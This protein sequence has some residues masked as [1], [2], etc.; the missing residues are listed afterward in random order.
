[1]INGEEFLEFKV[2]LGYFFKCGNRKEILNFVFECGLKCKGGRVEINLFWL[3]IVLNNF[4][5]LENCFKSCGLCG[6]GSFV[7]DFGNDNVWLN[8]YGNSYFGNVVYGK[9]Y[10]WGCW[11]IDWNW[12]IRNSKK[13]L[14]DIFWEMVICCDF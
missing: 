5:F 9:V 6:G 12:I 7:G 2:C 8:I 11:N 13:I 14:V 1:M 4:Y 10:L 3:I